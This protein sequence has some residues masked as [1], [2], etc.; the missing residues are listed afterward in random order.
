[1]NTPAPFTHLTYVRVTGEHLPWQLAVAGFSNAFGH[2]G[3]VPRVLRVQ[4][5]SKRRA[6]TELYGPPDHSSRSYRNTDRHYHV[7]NLRDKAKFSF[8][9]PSWGFAYTAQKHPLSLSVTP[10]KSWSEWLV[11]TVERDG[12]EEQSEGHHEAIRCAGMTPKHDMKQ[13]S[14][15]AARVIAG[16]EASTIPACHQLEQPK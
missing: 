11:G 8:T 13:V 16:R 3:S 4:R 15:K 12:R 5:R 9:G 1:M 7:A 2:L 10:Q 14:R 6:H